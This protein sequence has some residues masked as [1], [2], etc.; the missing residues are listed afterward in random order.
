MKRIAII[1]AGGLAREVRWV[2]DEINAVQPVHEFVG[3][4][5]SDLDQVSPHDSSEAILGDLSWLEKN[6]GDVDELAIG[7][8][9]PSVRNRIGSDLQARFPQL[10][11]PVLVHPSVRFDPHSCS[12]SSGVVLCAGVVATVGVRIAPFAY[13]NLSCTLGHEA[14]VGR[15]SVLNPTVNVS[16]GVEIG[17]RVLVGTGAQILQYLAVGDDAAV[18]AGA[19][20]NRPVEA[21]TTVVGV[22]AKPLD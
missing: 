3:F 1:G 13:I 14:K 4:L 21:G 12:F 7:I 22:P 2:L 10:A 9:N 5:V 8:G 11:W 19:L 17:D 18:G 16:G 6:H 15:G 20:V